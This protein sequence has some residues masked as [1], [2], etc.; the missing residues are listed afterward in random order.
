[1][2]NISKFYLDSKFIKDQLGFTY[3]DVRKFSDEQLESC[4]NYIQW[5]F[6]T[7]EPSAY[8]PNAP[9]PS[10]DTVSQF[11]EFPILKQRMSFLAHRMLRFYFMN[12][13]G[14]AWVTPRNHNFLRIT[15]ILKCLKFFKLDMEWEIFTNFIQMHLLS[16][17]EHVKIIG[18]ET[19]KYWS[20]A[21]YYAAST[22]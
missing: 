15:R 7:V 21:M 16:D 8:N 14:F 20:E 11:E 12:A 4:H 6:P 10:D 9:F 18:P 17:D 13:D 1:M 3:D 5:A 22:D 2:D 19:L